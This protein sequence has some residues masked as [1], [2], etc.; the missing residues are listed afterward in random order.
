MEDTLEK[1]DTCWTLKPKEMELVAV[2]NRD[3]RLGFALLLLHYRIHAQFPDDQVDIA[4]EAIDSV[5]RQLGLVDLSDSRLTD[6]ANRTGK[7]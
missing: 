7:G 5:A 3:N 6:L 2:K 1:R 4:P